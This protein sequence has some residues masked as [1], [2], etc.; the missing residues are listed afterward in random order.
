MTTFS[1][2]FVYEIFTDDASLSILYHGAKKSKMTKNPN[3]GG[4]AL[5]PLILSEKLTSSTADDESSPRK[6]IAA[7]AQLASGKSKSTARSNCGFNVQLAI[8]FLVCF[9]KNCCLDVPNS[10]FLV[11]LKPF[12]SFF[13]SA[14]HST[15]FW[16]WSDK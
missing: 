9:I 16:N 10:S 8:F 1:F 11:L 12:F 2:E 13:L 5:I 7:E 15:S 6:G 3:Q 14:V 4:P